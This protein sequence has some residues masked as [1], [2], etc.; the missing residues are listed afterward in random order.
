[1][2]C[3]TVLRRWLDQ[4]D[5]RPL[6][7]AEQS[8][9]EDHLAGCE[10]CRAERDI[11]RAIRYDGSNSPAPPLQGAP[12]DEWID[13]V[14]ER[15]ESPDGESVTGIDA[16]RPGGDRS[17]RWH[18]AWIAAAAALVLLAVAVWRWGPQHDTAGDPPSLGATGDVMAAGARVV[19][20][21][22]PAALQLGPTIDLY[23]EPGSAWTLSEW[24]AEVAAVYLERGEIFARVDPVAAGPS[25]SILT[26]AG[27]VRVTGTFFSVAVEPSPPGAESPTASVQVYRGVVT[28]VED[29]VLSRLVGGGEAAVLGLPVIDPLGLDQRRRADVVEANLDQLIGDDSGITEGRALEIFNRAV[30][31]GEEG[32]A[33]HEAPPSGGD[34]TTGTPALALRDTPRAAESEP[35]GEPTAAELLSRAQTLRSERSWPDAAD[36]YQELV[37]HYPESTEAHV[38]LISLGAVQFDHL[39]QP[40]EALA[41]FDA[42]LAAEPEGSLLPEACFGRARALVALDR[43]SEAEEALE[44]FL[45]DHPGAVQAPQAREML[46]GLR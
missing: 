35:V 2:D 38:S 21:A 1:M 23:A 39:D 26:A 34:E 5:G 6:T 32:T 15:A 43:Q 40:A 19:T 18:P 20:G 4:A 17:R 25:F 3:E 11:A 16:R 36:A 37:Q 28:L 9:I 30:T 33:D 8:S 12:R 24:N 7:P 44:Q 13:D 45:T 14:L 29:G 42:Y 10:S 22:G 31:G 46:D 27:E 41:S